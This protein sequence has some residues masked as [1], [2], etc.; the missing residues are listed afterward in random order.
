VN[1]CILGDCRDV[2]RK[3]V[4]DGVKVQTIVTSPPY[5]GLRNYGVD[6]Q[7]GLEETPQQYIANMV[8]VFS[9]AWD[10]LADNGTLWLNIG[11]SYSSHKDCKSVGQTLAKGTSR[12]SAHVMDLGLSRVRDSKMLKANGFKNKELMMIPARLAIAL[13]DAGWYLRQDIIWA[14]PN[15]MPESV[16]DRC[17][18]AHEYVFLL[19]KQPQYY[20]DNEAIQ[21]L[22]TGF[23]GRK[24]TTKKP[25][26]K[27]MDGDCLSNGNAQSLSTRTQE[28]W[29]YK[30]LQDKGLTTH[31]M[32]EKRLESKDD[33]YPIR[34]KRSVWNIPT[35]SCTEAHFAVMPEELVENCIL[36]GSKVGDI[37]FDPFM[38]SGTVGKVAQ[39]L[40]RKWLGAELNPEYI[41]IQNRRTAQQG[42]EFYY[43]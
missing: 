40:G 28:R 21:E 16:T 3:L 37:V 15:P 33:L 26:K 10:L 22:A 29:R 8:E 17:T 36:A 1:K 11:D 43:D 18:K 34:N 14:K 31:S 39:N 9:C 13:S 12:E 25:T 32:H 19:A 42:I 20:F 27:Y 23:D 30:N 41:D 2:M 24:D 4:A 6:G 5:Y 7:L 35:Q 38:G